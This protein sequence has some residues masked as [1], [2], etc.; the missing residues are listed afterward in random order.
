MS[1]ICCLTLGVMAQ[2]VA[3]QSGTPAVIEAVNG[4]KARVFLQRLQGGRLTFQPYQVTRNRTVPV[5]AV[6]SL[7]FYPDY[8]DE[9]VD[10]QC[11]V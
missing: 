11:R 5:E 9:A 1:L 4:M 6:E 2:E 8:D 7:S 10:Q 3:V